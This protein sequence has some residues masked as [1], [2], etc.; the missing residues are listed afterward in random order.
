M[1][2]PSGGGLLIYTCDEDAETL[3]A[4]EVRAVTTL[5][6]EVQ[7]APGVWLV[8]ATDGF[9]GVAEKF[10]AAPPIFVRHIAPV[11][12][13]VPLNA[14]PSDGEVLAD[15]LREDGTL[16][17]ALAAE[18][19]TDGEAAGSFSVQARIF[20]GEPYKPFDINKPLAEMFAE[21]TGATVDVRA[22]EVV[23]SVTVTPLPAGWARDF[24][25]LRV[26]PDA[27]GAY[28]APAF[29]LVG[30]SQV[31]ENLSGWAGGM[32]RFA[33]EEGQVSRSEFKLLE[34]VEL[35]GIPLPERGVALD[36]GA[37]PG[38]WTR[39][40]R[41]HGQY[42][43]AVDPGELDA[44]MMEDK[45]VR[46]LRMTAEAYLREPPDRFDLIV[47]DMRMDAR[48][49]ARL[50]VGYAPYLYRHGA[51]IMTLK[52]PERSSP[53]QQRKTLEDA[54]AVVKQKYEVI[55][56]R[57]LFHNRSEVTVALRPLANY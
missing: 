34:A 46:H 56:A 11:T 48:D 55:G 12:V 38:G 52:L 36:L 45:G 1:A 32:R 19:T 5:R 53:A 37:S 42:V 33:R 17:A 44:R 2:R 51:V 15:A 20:G 29:A 28:D 25:Q 21:A 31:D 24:A 35:F 14:D 9:E 22:P 16:T 54:L 39:I 26:L 8:I 23:V 40:L 50:M 3:A 57:Q 10:A 18:L 4:D 41:K 43:T 7:L 6:K 49:S 47:N 30:V 27:F 13:V